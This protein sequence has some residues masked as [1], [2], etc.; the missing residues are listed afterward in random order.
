[1]VRPPNL[2]AIASIVAWFDSSFPAPALHSSMLPATMMISLSG[3][4][5]FWATRFTSASVTFEYRST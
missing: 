2:A 4:R 1:M 5:Y 3:C